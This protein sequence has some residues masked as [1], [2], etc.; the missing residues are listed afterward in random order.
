[1]LAPITSL[2]AALLGLLIFLLAFRITRI[3]RRE[4]IGSGSGG[5]EALRCAIRAHGNA[6][7]Y[8]PIAL[9]LLLCLEL[10]AGAHWLLHTAGILLVAARLLHAWGLSHS[11]GISFGRFTGTALTWLVITVLA[12]LN[13]ARLLP[14]G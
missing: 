1:M 7:E 2:Y 12:A 13:I 6:V 10:N 4:Q 9:L 5:N 8:I 11:T 3:R 14:G